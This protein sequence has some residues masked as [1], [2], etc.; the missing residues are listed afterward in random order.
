MAEPILEIDRL[1]ISFFTRAAR[2]SR[3]DGLLLQ[4][5]AR[6]RRWDSSANPA[7]ASRRSRSPSCATCR[8]RQRSPAARSASRAATWRPCRKRSCAPSAA[9]RSPWSIRSR[10]PRSIRPCSIGQQLMEVPLIHDRVSKT[11][12]AR[13]RARHGQGRA[14]ARSRAGHARLSAPAFRRPAAAGR[15]RDG[16]AVE[17]DNC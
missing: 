4:G 5:H 6:A 10:W 14:P 7:A 8:G 11:E 15:D 2:N 3:G 16:A 1:G 17:S 9:R 13:A 12:A